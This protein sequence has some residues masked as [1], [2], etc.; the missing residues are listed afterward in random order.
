M[1]EIKLIAQEAIYLAQNEKRYSM[2][3]KFLN[4]TCC[5]HD[6]VSCQCSLS[7]VFKLSLALP[8]SLCHLLESTFNFA[9]TSLYFLHVFPTTDSIFFTVKIKRASRPPVKRR[10]PPGR[11]SQVGN[12]CFK[13]SILAFI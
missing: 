12:H 9:L 10:R 11:A 7:S 5:A 6:R 4:V 13:T 8:R 3:C 1:N 2:Q